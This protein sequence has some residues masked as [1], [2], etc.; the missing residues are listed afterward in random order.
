MEISKLFVLEKLNF[1]TIVTSDYISDAKDVIFILYSWPH[2]VVTLKR[3]I[4]L[5]H[6]AFSHSHMII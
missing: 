6:I 1:S 3:K 5:I 4:T 2:G